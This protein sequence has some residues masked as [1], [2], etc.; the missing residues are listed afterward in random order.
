M[1]YLV[2]VVLAIV[3]VVLIY[4][5]S[6]M[7]KVEYLPIYL[8]ENLRPKQEIKESK[9]IT[10]FIPPETALYT[11]GSSGKIE[12]LWDDKGHYQLRTVNQFVKGVVLKIIKNGEYSV[13]ET[14]TGIYLLKSQGL[15][16]QYF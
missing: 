15:I 8:K 5:K 13:V 2:V 3:A 4:K 16:L 11:I 10:V 12:K 9:K 1:K 14:E 6:D 7:G